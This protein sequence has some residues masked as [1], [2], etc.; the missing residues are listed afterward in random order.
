[1]SRHDA[2][3]EAAK[4]EGQ[5][6]ADE[7]NRR[8][9]IGTPVIAYPSVRPEDPVAVSYQ[10]HLMER[11]LWRNFEDPCKRLVTV[12]RTPAWIL[13]HGEPVVSV[14]GYAG[15]ICL[16]H[17]DIAP[18]T[19][20]PDVVSV[21]DEGRS[22]TTVKLKRCCNGCGTQLGDADNRD[23]DKNG[24]LTDVRAECVTCRP[25]VD[26]EAA[27]CRTWLL[28]RRG[29][30]VIDDAIDSYGVYAK[31]YWEYVDGKTTVTGLRIGSGEDR[32]V[33]KFG[34]WI[35]RHPDG[36]WS[37]HSTSEVAA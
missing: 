26:L 33:A 25:V 2:R 9:P 15:G 29:I 28:T 21:N 37:T 36:H 12:T 10:K 30:G 35:I 5:A 32:V 14:T 13:G 11:P 24:D 17:V 20:T 31:G 7:F 22:V 6:Q 4:R 8:Y 34:D 3:L 1:M 27:G 16:T 19:N 23:V 18:R